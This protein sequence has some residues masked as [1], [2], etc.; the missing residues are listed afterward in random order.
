MADVAL[1]EKLREM[2]KV[3]DIHGPRFQRYVAYVPR[4]LFDRIESPLTKTGT[5]MFEGAEV[6]FV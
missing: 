3:M 6:H 4:S 1:S 2:R 5:K